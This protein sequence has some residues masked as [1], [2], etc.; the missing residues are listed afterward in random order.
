M[1]DNSQDTF[2]SGDTG[3]LAL[4]IDGWEH[5]TDGNP[6]RQVKKCEKSENKNSPECSPYSHYVR[7]E[8]VKSR[9]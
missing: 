4:V 6:K 3:M 7:R 1:D 8:V 9:R 5:E 2:V